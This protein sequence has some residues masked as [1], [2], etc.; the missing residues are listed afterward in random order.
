MPY[1]VYLVKSYQLSASA[2]EDYLCEYDNVL[3]LANE[4]T[5]NRMCYHFRVHPNTRYIFFGDLDHYPKSIEHFRQLLHTFMMTKYNLTFDI[6]NDFKYTKNSGKPGS[7][8]YSIPCWNTTTEKLKEII[9]K[10]LKD[11]KDEFIIKSPTKDIVCVDTT[12][13]SEHW[14]RCPN[15]VKPNDKYNYVHEIVKGEM[16]DF[17]IDYIPASSINIDSITWINKTINGTISNYAI[18][19]IGNTIISSST[20]TSNTIPNIQ[21][22]TH[23]LTVLN[24]QSQIIQNLE[25]AE[26]LLSTSISKSDIYKKLFDE[27]FLPIRFTTYDNWIKVGMSIKNTIS[28]LEEALQLYIYYSSKGSNYEGSEITTRKFNS[29]KIKNNGYGIGTIYKMAIEDNKNNAVRIIGSNKLQFYSTDFCLFIK[30][31]VGNQF[32]YKKES[33]HYKLYCFTGKNWQ[34]DD[35]LLRH[36]ISNDLYELLKDLLIN[37]YWNSL[38]QNF[39]NYK[40]KLDKLKS[41]NFKKEIIET[42]KEYNTRTDIQFDDKWWLIGF[43]NVVYDMK[44]TCFREYELEDYITITTGY[45]WREPTNEEL[46]TVNN[47]IHS[48]MPIES[49]REAFLQILAS[50]IDGRCP[51]KFIIFN[52]SGGNGKGVINDMMLVMLGDYGLL[53]NNNILFESSKMGSNPEKANLHYKRFVVF[54][55]PSSNKKFENSVIKELTGGGK[56]SARGLY[57]S[58]TQKEILATIICEC[59]D[60]PDFNEAITKAEVRRII[61]IYFKS[62]FTDNAADVNPSKNIYKANK[63]YKERQFQEQHKYALF[64]ILTEYHRKFSID[65]NSTFIMPTTILNRTQNYL[66]NS[67]DLVAWFKFEYRPDEEDEEESYIKVNDI[68]QHFISSDA[69][70]SLNKTEKQ[71]YQKLKFFETMRNNLFFRQYYVERHY[72]DKNLIKGWR[73]NDIEL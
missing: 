10:F 4:L 35:I 32:I 47:L 40:N 3:E 26:T 30:A 52:G 31:M 33:G 45:D 53:G 65:N 39:Q 23:A 58:N 71:K 2:F 67:C 48:I 12:I 11:N 72:G 69:Y 64:K 55:E 24:N 59:N 14:F 66:E 25:N 54:R 46:E 19:N 50:G 57:E 17:I 1:S 27:C 16:I 49:E 37:V 56:I 68:Y 8:H 70:V 5:V 62:S 21:S 51:E 36:F 28:N 9:S 43:N 15:Q 6:E 7:Y 13:Y 29:Y 60:K 73:I 22:N 42:Y 44:A 61:D 63:K 34:Q 18:T 38:G 41:L 20:F